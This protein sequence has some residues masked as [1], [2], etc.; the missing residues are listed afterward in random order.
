MHVS[1]NGWH[2]LKDNLL[3]AQE[4]KQSLQIVAMSETF[5]K[6]LTFA[7]VQAQTRQSEPQLVN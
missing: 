2:F 1:K 4:F 5:G 3:F 6:Q 7:L